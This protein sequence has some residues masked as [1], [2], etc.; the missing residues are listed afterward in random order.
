MTPRNDLA[1]WYKILT[2]LVVIPI[3]ILIVPPTS[4]GFNLIRFLVALG[5][6][7]NFDSTFFIDNGDKS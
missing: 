7:I 5:W 3:L 1:P 2:R 6:D 4:L